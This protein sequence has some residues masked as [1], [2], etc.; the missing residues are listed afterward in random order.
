MSNETVSYGLELE[1]G[2]IIHFCEIFLRKDFF[3]TVKTKVDYLNR[4]QL[5]NQ[6]SRP[7][8]VLLIVGATSL[9]CL[10]CF[11]ACVTKQLRLREPWRRRRRWRGCARRGQARWSAVRSKVDS[12]KVVSKLLKLAAHDTTNY[13]LAFN[14]A[15]LH[16]S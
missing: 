9:V 7:Q 16:K 10:Y 6:I 3:C 14:W 1:F 2:W 13:F 8:T 4:P 12:C 11:L 5:P 15:K